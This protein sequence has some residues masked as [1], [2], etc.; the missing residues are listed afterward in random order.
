MDKE[1]SNNRRNSFRRSPELN[2]MRGENAI[3]G[4]VMDIEFWTNSIPFALGDTCA[5]K[6]ISGGPNGAGCECLSSY[7]TLKT[8]I[9]QSTG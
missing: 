6:P 9:Y 1:A 2:P 8:F 7:K 5:R 3:D 4:D